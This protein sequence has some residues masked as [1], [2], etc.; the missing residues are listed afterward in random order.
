MFQA[1][2]ETIVISEQEGLRLSNDPLD[3]YDALALLEK[4]NERLLDFRLSN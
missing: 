4:E 3:I 1:K 2:K